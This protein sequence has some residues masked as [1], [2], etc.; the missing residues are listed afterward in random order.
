MCDRGYPSLM[1]QVTKNGLVVG[2]HPPPLDNGGKVDL[3][4]IEMSS[5]APSKLDEHQNPFHN[6]RRSSNFTDSSNVEVEGR[7]YEWD[8]DESQSVGPSST[9][10]SLMSL[11]SPVQSVVLDMD[12]IES[13]SDLQV[14]KRK[15][16]REA[17]KSIVFSSI[18]SVYSV[19]SLTSNEVSAPAAEGRVIRKDLSGSAVTPGTIRSSAHSGNASG[20]AAPAALATSATGPSAISELKERW[21]RLIK[22]RNVAVLE[23]YL[24]GLEPGRPYFFRVQAHN[25]FGW[26][27]WSVW[28]QAYTPQEA[29]RVEQ[30]GD[31]LVR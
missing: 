23:K 16:R 13:E 26:S 5:E 27:A 14:D 1:V 29:V 31:A 12:Y 25:E 18:E 2:W 10:I 20:S 22:H 11:E 9:G 24:M 7:D 4:Q 8:S 19:A 30:A 3:Y 28:S 21:H 6:K 17:R 15:K